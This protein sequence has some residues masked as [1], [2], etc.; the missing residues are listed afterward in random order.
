MLHPRYNEAGIGIAAAVD[1]MIYW[2]LILARPL[3]P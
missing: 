1:E 2:V 3:D